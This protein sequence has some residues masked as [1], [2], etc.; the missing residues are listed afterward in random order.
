MK[1]KK[2]KESPN[3]KKY[4]CYK[5]DFCLGEFKT[6]KSCMNLL[7]CSK[8][9]FFRT[10]NNEK[11]YNW[12][13][14]HIKQEKVESINWEIWKK[15]DEKYQ[16]SKKTYLISNYWRVKSIN[17]NYF[18]QLLCKNSDKKNQTYKKIKLLGKLHPIHKLVMETFI[19][20]RPG[21]WY[22]INHIDT[23]KYNNRLDNLEYCTFSE[24]TKHYY[25]MWWVWQNQK[26]INQYDSNWKYLRSFTSVKEVSEIL[27]ISW[28]TICSVCSNRKLY[29]SAHWFM[30][31]YDNWNHNDI[32]PTKIKKSVNQYSLEG[33]FIQT[34]I[35]IKE[36]SEF[37]NINRSQIK[38][39]CWKQLKSAKW[40]I[41][42]YNNWSYS[43]IKPYIKT[44]S[45]K[46]N[47]YDLE[48]KYLKIFAS[49]G[50]ASKELKIVHSGITAVCLWRTKQAGWFIFK[51]A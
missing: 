20:S 46:I 1:F 24:N 35:W 17:K 26:P 37:L 3:V 33:K 40:F 12:F 32:Q 51:F 16:K 22:V 6:I 7:D 34:F 50:D 23:N 11:E 36:A 13:K 31:R 41:F 28:G 5:D 27:W 45:K 15:L 25:T 44:G 8:S 9:T 21:E 19:G 39:N 4:I 18:E 2:W 49:I 42:E 43:D 30:F 29:K 10:L 47:Q 48:W 38:D 14:V